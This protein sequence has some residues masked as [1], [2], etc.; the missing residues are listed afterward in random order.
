MSATIRDATVAFGAVYGALLVPIERRIV[1]YLQRNYYTPLIGDNTPVPLLGTTSRA[2]HDEIMAIGAPF[3][4]VLTD[5]GEGDIMNSF[6]QGCKHVVS[7]SIH[8]PKITRIS[9]SCLRD[10]TSLTSFDTSGLTSVTTIGDAFLD[11]CTLLSSFDTS[12]LTSVTTVGN[13][14][15]VGCTSLS[16][17]DTSGLISVKTIGYDFLAR[18][19]SLIAK[20]TVDDIY[21]RRVLALSG[22][23]SFGSHDLL[24]ELI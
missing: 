11:G 17:L 9:S 7:C 18:C 2:L 4:L 5:L 24:T 23:R 19:T 12:G 1:Q 3:H 8:A 22:L 15:L 13:G 16:S 6:L 10:C 14:F 20:P 21:H